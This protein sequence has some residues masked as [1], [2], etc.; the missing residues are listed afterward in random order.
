MLLD[1]EFLARIETLELVSRKIISGTMKG[2][3][4]SRRRGHSMEFADYRPYSAGD[5]LRF[6]DWNIYARLDRLFMKLF[7]EEED[8]TLTIL[9]DRSASMEFGSPGKL[10]YAKK[11]AAALGYIGLVNRDRVQIAGFSGSLRPLFGPA[12]G[13]RQASRLLSVLEGLDAERGDPTDLERSC[14]QYALSRSGGGILLVLTD[15]LDRGGVE[16]GLRY[17]LSKSR[18]TEI[19]AIHILSPEEIDPD[20]RGDLVLVDAEDGRAVEVSTS[21]GLLRQYKRS[22]ETFRESVKEYCTRHGIHYVFA[23]TSLP[24]DQLVLEYLRRRGLLR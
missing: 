23:S 24:F 3:R 2:D 16:A 7:L 1:P 21:V 14:R 11:V 13:R 15:F 9:V 17:L 8:L 19:F 5:D 20:V 4:L 6:L 22:L 10:A 12:R 18:S